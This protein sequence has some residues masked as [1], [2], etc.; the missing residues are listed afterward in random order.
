MIISLILPAYNLLFSLFLL[1][2]LT[3]L[4][5][6]YKTFI[7]ISVVTFLT[8]I[9]DV[10]ENVR[11]AVQVL[12]ILILFYLFLKEYGVNFTDYPKIPRDVQVLL[13]LLFTSMVVATIFSNYRWLGVQ[14]IT[15]TTVFFI[16]IYFLYSLIKD[17]YDIR[18]LLVALLTV[19]V[20]F[21]IA[22]IYGFY[23]NNFNIVSEK[24]NS[25]YLNM[26]GM[27]AYIIIVY[28]IALSFILMERK[29]G[30]RIVLSFLI[31]V[32]MAA[33]FITNSR[34][35]I[36]GVLLATIFLLF[37]I[38]KR[39]L[40]ISFILILLC[41]PILFIDP[42]SGFIDLYFRFDSGVTGRDVIWSIIYGI[43]KDNPILGVGPAATKFS[44][45]NHLTSM[46][47]SPAERLI[48][49]HSEEIE[50]GHA[51]NFY[52]FLWSDLGIPGL[53]TSIFLP[54]SF[55]KICSQNLRKLRSFNKEYYYLTI[56]ILASGV[57]LFI[58]GIYEWSCLISYGT[59]TSD[60][61]FWLTFVILWY[62][63]TRDI[64]KEDKILSLK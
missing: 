11:T 21:A 37:K 17:K 49:F 31:L 46:L 40:K 52:L 23:S 38:N 61:P 24:L 2:I 16:I 57:G 5:A 3:Y 45:Y 50:F 18:I 62:I 56:G 14:E 55:F 1:V 48:A 20:V 4:S 41:I 19:G 7:F 30:V 39:I 26:N 42:I 44:L 10:G 27:G 35:S 25:D 33:L 28:S 22:L 59:I 53:V 12:N 60:M 8:L 6:G 63:R 43:I 64:K 9:N 51:H 58:R 13:V 47:G 15:R 36:L 29:L 34:G 54:I 32:L